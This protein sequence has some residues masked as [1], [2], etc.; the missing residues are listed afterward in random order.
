MSDDAG[1]NAFER[2]TTYRLLVEA[3]RHWCIT[4]YLT[5][6][7]IPEEAVFFAYA[8]GPNGLDWGNAPGNGDGIPRPLRGK[9]YRITIALEENA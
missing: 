8:N 4:N 6:G 3:V 9:R 1:P 5:G 7:A 2:E